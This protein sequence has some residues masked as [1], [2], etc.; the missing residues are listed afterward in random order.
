MANISI[1]VIGTGN[2][3]EGTYLVV[4]VCNDS[5][6]Y[7]HTIEDYSTPFCILYR[8]QHYFINGNALKKYEEEWRQTMIRISDV[9]FENK[10]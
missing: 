1:P 5:I 2:D 6:T 10:I 7:I 4:K 3:S 8:N 9:P